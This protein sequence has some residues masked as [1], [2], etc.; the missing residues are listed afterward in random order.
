MQLERKLAPGTPEFSIVAGQVGAYS[1]SDVVPDPAQP[2]GGTPSP[3]TDSPADQPVGVGAATNLSNTIIGQWVFTGMGYQYEAEVDV[4][5]GG[6]VA[7]QVNTE[8]QQILITASHQHNDQVTV[9]G[10][11]PYKINEPGEYDQFTTAAGNYAWAVSNPAN[12][13][14]EVD[15]SLALNPT[16]ENFGDIALLNLVTTHLNVFMGVG[17]NNPDGSSGITYADADTG[18]KNVNVYPGFQE[19]TWAISFTVPVAAAEA[20]IYLSALRTFPDGTFTSTGSPTGNGVY[21]ESV[22]FTWSFELT[23]KP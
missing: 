23:L 5:E 16:Q 14:V 7:T 2:G 10:L 8:P 9:Y 1:Q 13:N 6:V 12:V 18:W 22:G 3:A 21:G 15:F 4:T 11:G 20:A 17:V 19:G